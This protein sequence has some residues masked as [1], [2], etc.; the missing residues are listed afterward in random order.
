LADFYPAIWA[1]TGRPR[2]LLDVACGLNPLAFPWMDLPVRTQYYAYDLHKTRVEFLNRFFELAGLAPLARLQDI[3]F[4]VPQERGD[5]ALFFKE[6][7]RFERNYDG[8]GLA[9]LRGLQA[10]Y[11]CVSFPAVSLHGRRDLTDHYRTYFR[12]LIANEPWRIIGELEY[13]SELVFCVET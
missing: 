4:G 1:L 11:L 8:G 2:I 6:L 9:L 12:H 3:A 5:V 10:Q 13:E 7:H